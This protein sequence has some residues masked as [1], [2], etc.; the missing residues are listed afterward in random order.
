MRIEAGELEVGD[1]SFSHRSTNQMIVNPR[2]KLSGTI[3]SLGDVISKNRPP[4]V[5]VEELFRGRLIFE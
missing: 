5:E 1:L 2:Q 4:I 3:R